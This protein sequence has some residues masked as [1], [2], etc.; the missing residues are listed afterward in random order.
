[1]GTFVSFVITQDFAILASEKLNSHQRAR[2]LWNCNDG[3]DAEW[4][5]DSPQQLYI[6]SDTES[7]SQRIKKRLVGTFHTRGEL[8][9]CVA[10]KLRTK[11]IFI[12]RNGDL[13][14]DDG[15]AVIYQDG[16]VEFYQNGRLHNL[17]GPSVIRTDGHKEWWVRGQLHRKEGPAII[18]KDG[19]CAYYRNSELHR[20]NGPAIIGHNGY[21]AYYENGDL[22]KIVTPAHHS[23][24][25]PNLLSL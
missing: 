6:L 17:F 23:W 24:L 21:R 1:M 3:I 4:V 18:D 15:P 2:R 8:I 9:S 13:H 7:D 14:K 25:N 10:E 11:N 12:N 20:T 5:A 16:T 19:Y 22:L